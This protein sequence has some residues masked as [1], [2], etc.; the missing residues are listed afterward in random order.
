MSGPM[1]KKI[2][3][4]LKVS[5]LVI[6]IPITSLAEDPVLAEQ[7]YLN[8]VDQLQNESDFII[9]SY[10]DWGIQGYFS[11]YGLPGYQVAIS[12]NG[13]PIADPLYGTP[14]FS[15]LNSRLQKIKLSTPYQM[16]ELTPVFADSGMNISRFDYY[17]GDYGFNN[18]ALIVSGNLTEE[19]DW[20]FMGENLGYDGGYGLYGPDISKSITQNYFLDIRK[21]NDS[22]ITDLGTSYQKFTPG[23]MTPVSQGIANGLD[24]L[25]WR[26]GGRLKEFR[27]NFY[28]R[29]THS[30]VNSNFSIGA[31]LANYYYSVL[32]DPALYNFTAD[33]FQLSGILKIEKVRPNGSLS[34][35][36]TP[37]I[38]KI[39]VR[40]DAREGQ[41]LF[42]HSVNYIKQADR[43]D[44]TINLGSVNLN[45]VIKL[46]GALSVSDRLRISISSDQDYTAYPLSFFTD[47][48]GIPQ[49]KP[50]KAGFSYSLQSLTSKYSFKESY[51]QAKI[52][53]TYSSLFVPHVSSLSDTMVSFNKKTLNSIYLTG[54]F[55][56]RLPWRMSI[57]SRAI[58]SPTSLDESS[59][60]F[61]GWSR[62][63]QEI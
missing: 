8:I 53:H 39:Y 22:W 3:I 32:N 55:D 12:Y 54:E 40:R 44:Y 15:W 48:G 41:K 10:D 28:V 61:Q 45:P 46:S 59:I 25:S 30:K 34:Y 38:E 31:Q 56:F 50:D 26:H 24:Y 36:A 4:I 47:I 62:L 7:Q 63:Y 37:I 21:H 60:T 11:N 20:R 19:I 23:L 58:F 5:I 2:K 29:G 33:G 52:N 43:F 14:P 49:N 57:K 42:R 17:R 9:A 1:T 13:F 35:S 6:L 27:T 18:F 51:I 16:I